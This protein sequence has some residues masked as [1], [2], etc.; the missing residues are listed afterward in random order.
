[1]KA[2]AKSHIRVPADRLDV[3]AGATLNLLDNMIDACVAAIVLIAPFFMGGR[4]PVGQFVFVLL[5]S[6][7]A[8]LWFGRQALAGGTLWLRSGAEWLLVLGLLLILL[9]LAP[10]PQSLLVKFS[11]A[12][13]DL[14]PLWINGNSSSISLGQWSTLSLAPEATRGG[15]TIYL[16]Y[17]I[18]FL[19][20][21]QRLKTVSDI[22]L[23]LKV[24]A[25]AAVI[26]AAVGLAQ[27]FL[28]SS[29]FL[30]VYE[31]ISRSPSKVVRGAF[32]NENHLAHFLTLGI[33]PLLWWLRNSQHAISY[34]AR[35]QSTTGK[36]GSTT[37]FEKVEQ[38]FALI[39]LILV[40]LA[41]LLT[42]SRGGV[43]TMAISLI[44]CI[45]I[46]RW[47]SLLD[48]RMSWILCS[49]AGVNLVALLLFGYEPLSYQL[50]TVFQASSFEELFNTRTDLWNSMCDAISRFYITGTGVGSHREVYPIYMEE[51]YNVVFTHG[52]SGYLPLFLETGIGGLVLMLLGISVSLFWC[53]YTLTRSFNSVDSS[54]QA[55]DGRRFINVASAILPSVIASVVHSVADFVWYIPACMI[56]TI[57]QLAC[58]CRIYQLAS[59]TAPKRSHSD[60][61][62]KRVEVQAAF[63]PGSVCAAFSFLLVVTGWLMVSNRL[64]PALAALDWDAYLQ[65]SMLK[66]RTPMPSE[67]RQRLVAMKQHLTKVL[68]YNPRDAEAQVRLAAVYLKEFEIAQLNAE[69]SMDLAQIRDAALASAFPSKAAQ[70]AWLNVAIGEHR[71][72]LDQA[73]SHSR[74]AVQLSPLQGLGYVQLAS[75]CFLESPRD[76][77]KLAYI[78]Q[79][80]RVRP[81]DGQ[82]LFIRGKEAALAGNQEEAYQFWKKA[83]TQDWEIRQLLIDS[84]ADQVPADFFV[85][86][87]GPDTETLGQLFDRYDKKGRREEATWVSGHYLAALKKDAAT[88]SPGEAADCWQRAQATYSWLGDTERALQCQQQVLE[89]SPLNFNGRH[90]FANLLKQQQRYAEAITQYEWCL[91]RQPDRDDLRNELADAKMRVLQSEAYQP[92]ATK[93][94]QARRF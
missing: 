93:P 49:C 39:G 10:L 47:A 77:M 90:T 3:P 32:Q 34:N 78:E 89:L 23:L 56:I 42:L 60:S 7:L 35:A 50:G 14:L 9:Q 75:L 26:M 51:K 40:A 57:A 19:V 8:V 54:Y 28:G 45:G 82:V 88:K 5:S 73:Q 64:G 12:I 53:I 61:N 22:S 66:G 24:I 21:V 37:A 41:G 68:Q 46:L 13:K 79:A 55:N 87:F 2:F 4:G 70:D 27:F 38:A 25:L 1:M 17:V 84:L 11:P 86:T 72:L 91:R 20:L 71:K 30:W 18:L 69:N 85:T 81:N 58:V 16:A 74:L 44:V 29:K 6:L 62:T 33:G 48:R 43:L 94:E 92:V 67:E 63:I 59:R 36:V 15:L 83:F 31:H 65:N 76:D 52:E 80:A